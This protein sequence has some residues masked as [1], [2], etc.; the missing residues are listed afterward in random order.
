[1]ARYIQFI[2]TFTESLHVSFTVAYLWLTSVHHIEYIKY[3]KTW[4][5]MDIHLL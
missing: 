1:M 5:Q 2:C 4:I 3:S